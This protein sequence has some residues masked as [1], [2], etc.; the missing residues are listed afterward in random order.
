MLAYEVTWQMLVPY[1]AGIAFS[2]CV[3][4]LLAKL[5]CWAWA[6]KL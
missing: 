4:I 3:G 5:F 6:K 1:Y 2:V